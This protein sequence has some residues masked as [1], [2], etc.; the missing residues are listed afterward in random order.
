MMTL[1]QRV[2]ERLENMSNDYQLLDSIHGN[3]TFFGVLYQ[4]FYEE[5]SNGTFIGISKGWEAETTLFSYLDHYERNILPA[6]PNPDGALEYFSSEDFL[7]PIDKMAHRGYIVA[8]QV[9]KYGSSYIETHKRL[10]N[11]VYQKALD[12]GI[13]TIP[14]LDGTSITQRDITR[15]EI[16][17]EKKKLKKSFS[18]AQQI[19]FF[20]KLLSAIRKD[21]LNAAGEDIGLLI[22]A[23]LGMRNH[24]VAGLCFDDLLQFLSAPSKHCFLVYHTTKRNSNE[25]TGGGKTANAPRGL[26]VLDE[27]MRIIYKRRQLLEE[28]YR[29]KGLCI[30]IGQLPIACKGTDYQR[31]CT[32]GDISFAGKQ[33]LMTLFYSAREFAVIEEA[34]RSE[35][36][37]KNPEL[38]LLGCD[39]KDPTTYLL[40]RNAITNMYHCGFSESEIQFF[41]GHKIEDIYEDRS[42]YVNEDLLVRLISKLEQHPIS[43]FI[44][45]DSIE[46]VCP[47][48]ENISLPQGQ[49]SA[50][51]INSSTCNIDIEAADHDRMVVFIIDEKEPF[52]HM[53]AEIRAFDTISDSNTTTN[54]FTLHVTMSSMPYEA[55]HDRTVNINKDLWREYYNAYQILLNSRHHFLSL[56]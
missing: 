19:V 40:R 4:C 1:K 31:R 21:I 50:S 6:F 27:I 37:S 20:D 53:S 47:E 10:I 35:A 41:A 56:K 42:D 39:E 33:Y 26:S 45:K 51:V 29:R 22:M 15:T 30:D 49:L 17:A 43:Q 36:T 44:C 18:P 25:L 54:P 5:D 38:F 55:N 14:V 16:S 13:I 52:D 24:E 7:A 2:C 28:H 48:G 23:T 12:K 32:S 46:A 34:L 9:E 8:G 3:P 11:V